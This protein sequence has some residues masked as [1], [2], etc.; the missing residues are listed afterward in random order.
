MLMLMACPKTGKEAPSGSLPALEDKYAFRHDGYLEIQTSTG[1][2]HSF[3]IE[4]AET[5][6]SRMQ[7]LMYREKMEENQAML[8]IF[9][10]TDYQSFWMKDTYIP[11]DMLFI[12][13]NGEILQIAE[14]TTPFSE[15]MIVSDNPAKY[16]L[17]TN[18][19]ISHKLNIKP[20]DKIKWQRK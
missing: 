15:D 3:E 5:N 12:N 17:E 11:L 6:M 1:E 20:G 4:I 9:D 2:K 18:A 19:G 8:F 16:V 10:Y 14:N 13:S 7:G